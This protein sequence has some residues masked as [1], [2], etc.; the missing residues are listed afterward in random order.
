MFAT[1]RRHLRQEQHSSRAQL[2]HWRLEVSSDNRM[3][4]MSLRLLAIVWTAASSSNS[5][6]PPHHLCLSFTTV[7]SPP[8]PVQELAAVRRLSVSV[9]LMTAPV[10]SARVLL[11]LLCLLVVAMARGCKTRPGSVTTSTVNPFQ[12]LRILSLCA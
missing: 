6:L 1:L 3:S 7:N 11:Y 9:H 2:C 8:T 10:P 12:Q 4:R 5:D